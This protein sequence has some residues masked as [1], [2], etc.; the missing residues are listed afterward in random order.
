[1]S[2][3]SAAQK[4]AAEL[5]V[6]AKA[7]TPGPW[8]TDGDYVN[9][10]GNVLQ[11]YIANGRKAG[12]RIASAFANCLVKT[13]EQ[14]RANAAFVAGANPKAVL[15]MAAEIERLK[16]ENEQLASNINTM[17]LAGVEVGSKHNQM[18][19]E[20]AELRKIISECANA[21]GAAVSVE[22]SLSFMAD[23]PSEISAV[24][25]RL[26]KESALCE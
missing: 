19:A 3:P 6:L 15:V 8:V 14:C 1:M 9:E 22:C 17:G 20:C 13:D 18:K 7:A 21:C 26:R 5:T 12:G 4:L 24:L 25:S 10:H 16:V 11:S 2:K 23:L